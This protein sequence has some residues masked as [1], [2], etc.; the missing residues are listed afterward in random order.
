MT[1]LLVK[2]QPAANRANRASIYR[3]CSE[4]RRPSNL[5]L[6]FSPENGYG[7]AYDAQDSAPFF[8]A[9]K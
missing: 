9:N 2:V 1:F 7:P 3:N 5:I 6:F 4:K 8:A